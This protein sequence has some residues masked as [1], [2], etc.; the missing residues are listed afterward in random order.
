LRVHSGH[1]QASAPFDAI[2]GSGRAE[3]G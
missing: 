3:M 2:V 1:S